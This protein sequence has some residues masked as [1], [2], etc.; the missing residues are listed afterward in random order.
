MKSASRLACI[1]ALVGMSGAAP[2][3]IVFQDNFDT[4]GTGINTALDNWEITNGT[5]DV[6]SIGS[7]G[8]T[9]SPALS[10]CVDLDGSSGNA[11]RI[12]S[13]TLFN[14]LAGV[15]YQLSYE[16]S[17]NQRV[18][19]PDRLTVEFAGLTTVHV[20]NMS[21]PFD[22]YFLTITPSVDTNTRI[23]F[24]HDGGDNF[25]IILDNVILQT[26]EPT[27]APE[28]GSLALLGLG[29]AGLAAG[30]RKLARSR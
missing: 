18:L 28:P 21:D 30:R 24:D 26:V 17:G 5:I 2:A 13:N 23:V 29:L 1:L 14:L 9:C 12:E 19:S 15:T 10:I 20:L 22:T 7:F 16:L 6:V 25:G 4:E 27:A 3:A 11:G 8:L